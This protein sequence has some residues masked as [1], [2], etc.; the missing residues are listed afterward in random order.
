MSRRNGGDAPDSLGGLD[1]LL[2]QL[3]RH[4]G[5]RQLSQVGLEGSCGTQGTWGSALRVAPA[6]G[7]RVVSLLGILTRIPPNLPTHHILKHPLVSPAWW[8]P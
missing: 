7:H 6:D 3:E 5:L 8:S 1:P 4:E 2:I